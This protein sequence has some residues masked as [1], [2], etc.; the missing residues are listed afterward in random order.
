MTASSGRSGRRNVPLIVLWALAALGLA[1][2]I[3]LLAVDQGAT[4]GYGWTAYPPLSQIEAPDYLPNPVRT[5][6]LGYLVL[7][8]GAMA[9]IGALV[10]H[11]VRSALRA[12]RV[13]REG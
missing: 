6:D 2:G 3:V 12:E 8:V 5:T 13:R 4:A 7:L 11:G 10:L 1:A 9:L